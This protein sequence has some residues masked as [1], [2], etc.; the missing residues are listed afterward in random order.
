MLMLLGG[1]LFNFFFYTVAVYIALVFLE[2]IGKKRP[3]SWQERTSL[4]AVWAAGA[5]MLQLIVHAVS[6][7][8]HGGLN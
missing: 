3:G 4:A 1:Y 7:V 2:K 8:Y 6:A 5:T